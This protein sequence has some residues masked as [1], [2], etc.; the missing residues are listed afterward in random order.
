VE[1]DAEDVRAVEIVCVVVIDSAFDIVFA[2][3]TS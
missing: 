1:G 3:C 2:F